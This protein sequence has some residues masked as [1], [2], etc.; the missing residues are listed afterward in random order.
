L[1]AAAAFV[2]VSRLNSLFLGASQGRGTACGR[3]A[4]MGVERQTGGLPCADRRPA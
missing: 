1:A 2:L 3:L 4:I